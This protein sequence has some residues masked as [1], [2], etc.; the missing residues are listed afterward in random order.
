MEKCHHVLLACTGSVATIKLKKLVTQVKE[1]LKKVIIKIVL[2]KSSEFFLSQ[3]DFDF[4]QSIDVDVLKDDN[5]WK[6]WK[7][8]GD[9]ILHIELVKWADVLI[10]APLDANT[11]AKLANGICNNLLTCVCRAWDFQKP[12]LYAPAM[13]TNM[14]NH[15]IT[16]LHVGA[17]NSWGYRIINPVSK[18]LACG[19]KG[20]GAMA[21]VEQIVNSLEQYLL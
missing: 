21:E 19:D 8:V 2:T 16:N 13:N 6:D 15:P 12:L 10:I 1:K 9:S 3:E 4:F 11:M 17:L 7:K 20:M 14:W 18:L 5:E